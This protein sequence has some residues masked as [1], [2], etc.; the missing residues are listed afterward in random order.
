MTGRKILVSPL[1]PIGGIGQG[2]PESKTE[3]LFQS[4]G[5]PLQFSIVPGG[6]PDFGLDDTERQAGP[7]GDLAHSLNSGLTGV[8]HILCCSVWDTDETRVALGL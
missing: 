4:N 7:D 3:A 2:V 5:E 6:K 8:D 1:R